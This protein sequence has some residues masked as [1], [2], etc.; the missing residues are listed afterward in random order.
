MFSSYLRLY[1]RKLKQRL[2]TCGWPRYSGGIPTGGTNHKNRTTMTERQ[3]TV[4]GCCNEAT[5]KEMCG[6]HYVRFRKYGD[7]QADTPIREYGHGIN[8]G[9]CEHCDTPAYSRGLC[10]VHYYRVRTHGDPHQGPKQRAR[11][12]VATDGKQCGL[13]AVGKGLCR[14]HYDKARRATAQA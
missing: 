10:P 5:Y 9:N 4:D 2:R 11:C 13:P 3:C 6:T 7:V 14:S 1:R 8:N 12:V